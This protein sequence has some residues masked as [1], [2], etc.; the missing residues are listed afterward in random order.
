MS[1]QRA[2][3]RAA[4]EAE[5]AAKAQAVAAQREREAAARARRLA[6]WRRARLWQRSPNRRHAEVRSVLAAAV[7]VLLVLAYLFIGSWKA[8][9]GAALVLVIVSP[10][11][12][13]FGFDKGKP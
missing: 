9:V 2:I 3:A 6:L 8:V 11:V 13:K 12:L 10:L 4:R 7:L 5:A 1:K